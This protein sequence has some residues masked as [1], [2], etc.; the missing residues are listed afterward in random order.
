MCD[1]LKDLDINHR[2]HLPH[3]QTSTTTGHPREGGPRTQSS[4]DAY[5]S[6]ATVHRDTARAIWIVAALQQKQCDLANDDT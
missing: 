3:H 4:K 5:L 1:G 2:K 6:Q